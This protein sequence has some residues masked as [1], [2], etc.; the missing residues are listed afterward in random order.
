MD[1]GDDDGSAD[2]CDRGERIRIP[3]LAFSLSCSTLQCRLLAF[4]VL[5]AGV[6]YTI[7]QDAGGRG[8]GGGDVR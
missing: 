1:S 5:V 7:G 6:D 8:D 4:L 3:F 2:L